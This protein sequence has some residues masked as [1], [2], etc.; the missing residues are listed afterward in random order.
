VPTIKHEA[1]AAARQPA[2]VLSGC[3]LLTALARRERYYGWPLPRG[4]ACRHAAKELAGD[5]LQGAAPD[6]VEWPL[7]PKHTRRR[8]SA[9]LVDVIGKAVEDKAAQ[10][11]AYLARQ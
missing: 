6:A 3:T 10:M 1:D 4:N 5:L 8:V 7:R 2:Q 9:A 11:K